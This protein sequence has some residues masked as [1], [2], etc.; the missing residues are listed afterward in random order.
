MQHL[1]DGQRLGAGDL[2]VNV[3]AFAAR[4]HQ[5]CIA[6]HSQ[7]LRQGGLADAQG[8]FELAHIA[9]TRGQLAQQQKT[10]R[11]GQ[12]LQQSAGV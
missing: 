5:L 10:V 9:L 12:H 8:S 7:L 4:M 6:Q 11:V 2:V 3:L 1:H